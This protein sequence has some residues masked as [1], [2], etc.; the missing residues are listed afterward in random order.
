MAMREGT[1]KLLII[2]ALII[3]P[4]GVGKTGIRYLLLGLPPPSRRTSTLLLTRPTRALSFFRIKADGTS[5]GEVSWM[6]LNDST[7]LKFI[8]EE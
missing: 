4:P 2:K 8:A 1:T 5:T 7:H 6:E 3:G